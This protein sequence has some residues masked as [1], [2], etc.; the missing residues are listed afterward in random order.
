MHTRIYRHKRYFFMVLFLWFCYT[1][2]MKKTLITWG[3]II[4]VVLIVLGYIVGNYN[5]LVRLDQNVQGKWAAVETDYQRRND[6]IPNLVQT[7]KGVSNF[8]QTTLTQV[9]EAR[10]KATSIQVDA[11]K[12]TPETIAQFEAA[13]SQVQSTLGRL[14]AVA[15]AYPQLNATQSY[16]DLMVQL[17]GTEN[18]IGVSRKDFN[19]AVQAYNVQVRTFPSNIFALIFG[20][21]QKGFF[22]AVEGADVAPTVN[23]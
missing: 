23:F 1:I 14:L 2:A 16:R 15:E 17:E 7:V 19:N 20:F 18:R 11:S 3:S 12:L 10:S 9:I 13:Q 5:S 22:S 21:D 8:E 4:A 6:L